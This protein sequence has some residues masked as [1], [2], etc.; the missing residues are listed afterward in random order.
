MLGFRRTE[1]SAHMKK[2]LLL[3]IQTAAIWVALAM[4]VHAWNGVHVNNWELHSFHVGS[5]FSGM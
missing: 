4:L 2:I 5:S 1:R 3:T